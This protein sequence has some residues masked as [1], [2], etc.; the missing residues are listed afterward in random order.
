MQRHRRSAF[1]PARGFI[2]AAGAILGLGFFSP[3]ARGQALLP[4]TDED[5]PL[6][7]SSEVVRAAKERSSEEVKAG[8]LNAALVDI[9]AAINLEPRS[10]NLHLMRA[11]IYARKKLWNRAEE[12]CEEGVKLAPN[13]P[14]LHYDLAE[15]KFMSRAYEDAK[16]DFIKLEHD[17]TLGDLASYKVFLCDLFSDN[18]DRAKQ[19]LDAFDQV[20]AH[21]SYFFAH[22][23]WELT[24]GT[25]AE[26]NKWLTAVEH[27]YDAKTGEPYFNA[28]LES[29]RLDAPRV[30][31]TTNDGTSY[32]DVPAF[33]EADG[34][35]VFDSRGWVTVNYA[36]I[37]GDL[38]GF[39]PDMQEFITEKK[40]IIAAPLQD[41]RQVS[42]TTR[43]GRVFDHV[44]ALIDGSG[45]RVNGASGW[46]TVPFSQLPV[47]LSPFPADWQKLILGLDQELL[48][49]DIP[50]LTF[51]TR[52]GKKYQQ[53]RTL[54]GR[55]S[56]S[57]V[58]PDGWETIPFSNLP[59]DLSAFPKNFRDEIKQR[60]K[61]LSLATAPLTLLPPAPDA[62]APTPPPSLP[63][64]A[65]G[66]AVWNAAPGRPMDFVLKAQDCRF[67]LCLALQGL[68]LVVGGY[69]ATYVFENSE[70]KARLSPDADE[71]GTGA[72]VRSVAISGDTIATSTTKGV[73]L[74]TYSPAGWQLQQQL[75]VT[76]A[77]TV[78]L[79]GDNLAIG[80][81]GHGEG[82][83]LV[84]FYQRRNG[85]W[86]AVK[87]FGN[88]SAAGPSSDLSGRRIALQGKEAVLGVPNWT[89]GSRDNIGAAYAGRAWL[90]VLNGDVW[91][92]E[93]NLTP[94]DDGTGTNQFGANVAF[95]GDLL[96]IGCSNLDND[97]EPHPGTVYLFQRSAGDW[98]PD[99]LSPPPGSGKKSSFGAGA[100][101][102][103]GHTLVVA[104]VNA[105]AKVSNVHLESG[106]ATAKPGVITNA[107]AVDVYQDGK[108]QP[109]LGALDPVDNVDRSGSPDNFAASLA[110][111]GDMLAVGA[112]GRKDGTGA[113][114]LW[115]RKDGQWQPAGELNGY[116]P[117]FRLHP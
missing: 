56:L 96:A 105:D 101:A 13:I 106:D 7:S 45:L 72:L 90:K 34:L 11:N 78:A 22:A 47:D 117:D 71:T 44:N 9:D 110:L 23:A 82:P 76:A 94:R 111:D 6:V 80:L 3:A 98:Q 91:R 1:L 62:P 88:E 54:I 100:L 53:V 93:A 37:S 99:I 97:P 10:A 19:E 77:A 55:T 40:K 5:V 112:P 59:D 28:L 102:L 15:L 46:Q 31:F 26:A 79:D 103:S 12:D 16:P 83:G 35:R 18:K 63:V 24:N 70:L 58:T 38:S 21:P 85:N 50:L 114:Y 25:R 89:P 4:S 20:R 86:Q 68:R 104:D 64:P 92:P 84:S 61:A 109:P 43:D 30:N 42:F 81:D 107:G 27:A 39:P 87:S 57:V 113:V 48:P 65:H 2:C 49:A 52:A 33:C 74:W 67:G 60:E 17:R 69:G 51:V 75:A 36:D 73:Y 29:D 116:H 14:T 95:S 32:P 66:A 8:K 108:W 115:Q 41:M